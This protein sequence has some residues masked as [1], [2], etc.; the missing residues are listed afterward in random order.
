MELRSTWWEVGSR[1][2]RRR[3]DRVGLQDHASGPH[4]VE[5]VGL[6]AEGLS[7]DEIAVRLGITRKTVE[8]YLTRL[9]DRSGFTTRTELAIWAE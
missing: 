2:R 1:P 7:N 5:V 9:F 6:M 3:P 4:E 8:A